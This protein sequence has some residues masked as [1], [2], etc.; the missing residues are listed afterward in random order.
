LLVAVA[1]VMLLPTEHL[2]LVVEQVRALV[3]MEQGQ[4]AM[5]LMDYQQQ[6]T[7]AQAVAVVDLTPLTMVVLVV[8]VLLLFA[9]PQDQWLPQAAQHT[10]VVD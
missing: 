5:H 1:V 7:Q 8:Q 2:Q 9:T 3:V 10:Q 4:T 6:L